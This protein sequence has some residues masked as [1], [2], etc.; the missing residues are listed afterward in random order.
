MVKEA[1]IEL[2]EVSVCAEDVV[3]F[4]DGPFLLFGCKKNPVCCLARVLDFKIYL[5][6]KEL[7]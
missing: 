3:D 4:F 2:E 5:F 6:V 1:L 7:N